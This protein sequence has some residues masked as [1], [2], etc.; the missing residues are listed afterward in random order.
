MA[1]SNPT[2]GEVL[3]VALST[4]EKVVEAWS[5][6][7]KGT[8]GTIMAPMLHHTGS[9]WTWPRL[10]APTLRVVRDGRPRLENSLSMYYIDYEGVIYCINNK[11]S[12]HSGAGEFRGITDGNG[13][14]AGIEAESDGRQWTGATIRS[15]KKLAAAILRRTGNDISWAPRHA[16]YALPRG[17]KSDFNGYDVAQF[18]RDAEAYRVNGLGAS[19]TPEEDMPDSVFVGQV[20]PGQRV[21]I[22]LPPHKPGY[23]EI[24][25]SMVSVSPEG[26]QNVRVACLNG[27]DDGTWRPLGP[28]QNEDEFVF[29]HPVKRRAAWLLAP[30]DTMIDLTNGS[31]VA[32]LGYMVEVVG[33]KAS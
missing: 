2:R 12:W 5:S 33:L 25:F 6:H 26:G 27:H 21:A 13:R 4:G 19:L 16:D 32:S 24:W 28:K 30:G 20:E 3:A 22:P 11:L 18:R 31:T 14:F 8:M 17:R 7:N 9:G 23:Q 15:F 1:W 29:W 10:K